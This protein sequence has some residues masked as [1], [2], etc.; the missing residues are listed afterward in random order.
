M[1]V[2]RIQDT[3]NKV[4][5][6]GAVAR[7][8]YAEYPGE[9]EAITLGFAP[10]KAYDSVGIGRHGNYMLWGWSAAPSKMTPAAQK[11]FLNCLCYIHQYDRK[12]FVAIPR[13][14][15]TRDQDLVRILDRIE[16]SPS[17]AA[18]YLPRYFPPETVKQYESDL[19]GL[20]KHYESNI[21]FVYVDQNKFCIDEDLKSLGIDSNRRAATIKTLIGL[22]ADESKARVA[23]E[24]LARYTD[25][26]FKS[27]QAWSQWYEQNTKRL[28][29]SDA[30][31][32]R[33]Y[34]IPGLD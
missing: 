26:A 2:C 28:I 23:Q 10:G 14:A 21:E 18:T 31:G 25:R 16:A 20:R 24:C 29:F 33:F 22:L 4:G 15:L 1:N 27:A 30:G 12:P 32:Y 3:D 34:E 19:A 13:R 7:G 17:S 8:I 5:E 11:L 9:A 6:A